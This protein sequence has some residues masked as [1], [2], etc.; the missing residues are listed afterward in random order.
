MPT[1]FDARARRCASLWDVSTSSLV[2]VA[3]LLVLAGL[4]PAAQ[5]GLEVR[6][7]LRRDGLVLSL[8]HPTVAEGLEG[9]VLRVEQGATRRA[10]P[11]DGT[12]TGRRARGVS[13]VH[14]LPGGRRAVLHLDAFVEA[15]GLIV[16]D[17]HDAVVVDAV[18]GRDLT[19]SPDRRYWAFEEHASRTIAQWPHTETVYAIYDAAAP[20]GGNVRPCP[21]ADDRCRGQ[22]VFLPDR[23]TVCHEV[24]RARGGSCLTPG[25]QPRHAR[26]SPFQ[27]LSDTDVAWVD[28]DL[29][30]QVATLVVA[31]LQDDG[32]AMVTAVVLERA[33][34]I[35]DVEFPPVREAWVIDRISRDEDASRVWL[36]FRTRLPQAPQQRLGVRLS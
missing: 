1:G 35:E 2:G 29:A 13:A 25:G 18:V 30:R 7:L 32:P 34:V 19:P 33:N 16:A 27:W 36:H 5:A 26:R 15:S 23:L 10:I 28:V 31:R 20:P 9:S 14:V 3:V 8:A 12:V 4:A 6:E 17:L 21:T 24:A 11:L 22:V